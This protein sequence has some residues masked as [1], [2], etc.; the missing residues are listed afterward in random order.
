MDRP[1]RRLVH[2]GCVIRFVAETGST[3]S[4]LAAQLRAGE[5]VPEGHWLVADRQFAGRGRQARNWFDSTGNFMGSTLVSHL[6][7]VLP[8]HC[9]RFAFS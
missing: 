9:S 6:R 4:D 7:S 8:F 2:R 5:T 3:N 1:G